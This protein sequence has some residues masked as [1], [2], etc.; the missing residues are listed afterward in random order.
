MRPDLHS[1][2]E[3]ATRITQEYAAK[4]AKI[5][6]DRDLSSEGRQRRLADLYAEAKVRL[7]KLAR[8]EQAQLSARKITLEQRLYGASAVTG[9]LNPGAHAI[10][11]RDASDRVAQLKNPTEALALLRRAEA[12]G[13]ELLARA[14]ARRSAQ[15]WDG[16]PPQQARAWEDVLRAYLDARPDLEPVVEELAE[17][18]NLTERR[19][20]SPF[21]VPQPH[22]VDTRFI[23]EAAAP[24]TE[25]V[26]HAAAPMAV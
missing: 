9:R 11:A 10:S 20:L 6:E 25:P 24:K 4:V 2:R 26:T 22:G 5:R 12:D 16:V 19:V 3:A 18:E 13:D 23:N 14:V 17:I 15:S 8:E 1:Q 7:Q 21:S